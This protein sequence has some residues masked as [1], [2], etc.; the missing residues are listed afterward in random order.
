MKIRTSKV[1]ILLWSLAVQFMYAQQKTITGTVSDE[2]GPLP[3]VTVL[4]KNT[5]QG[6]ETDF[7][8]N[9]AIK[10]K[11]GDVLVFSYIGMKTTEK[12]VGGGIPSNII[13]VVMQS[14]NLLEEV[15]VTALG[16]KRDKKSL[17]YATQEVKGDAVSTVKTT[18]FI[19]SLSGQ[20]AGLSINSTGTLGG[21]ANVVIRGNSS[22]TG[23]NQA[24][25][26]VDG[27]PIGNITNTNPNDKRLEDQ[28]IGKGG[29]DYGNAASDINPDDIESI[30][31]LKGAAAT[32]LYG[33][34]GSN[35]VIMITTKKGKRTK[36]LGITISSSATMST[37]DRSTLPVY[38]N[39]YGAGYGQ[40]YDDPS[41]YFNY[42]DVDGDGSPDLTTP[43]SEDASFG[44]AFNPNTLVYQWNSIYPDLPTYQKATPWV[45]AKNT[46]NSIWEVGGTY[47]NSVSIDGGSDISTFR[48]GFTNLL[49]DGNLPNSNIKRNSINFSAS[50]DI[51]DKLTASVVLNYVK[52]NGRG[53]YGTGYNGNNLMQS[54]RQWWQVNVDIEQ[55]KQAY[56]A[57]RRNISWNPNSATN[58][59]PIFFDNP[60][61]VLYENFQT[62]V[63]NRYYGNTSLNWKVNNWLSILGRFAF[64]TYSELQEERI[65][66]GS[67]D[68]SRYR[69]YNNNVSE[70]NYDLIA[71]FNTDIS[72]KINFDG[73][74]G[75][76][77]RRNERNNITA[78]TNGGLAVAGLFSLSNSVNNPEAPIEYDEIQMVDGIYGRASFGFDDTYF[79]EGT[80]RTDRNSSLPIDKNRYQYWS[81]T[82]SVLLSKLIDVQ[83]L[84]FSKFRANYGTVGAGTIPY[85]IYN[86][87][88]F[89]TPF[90]NSSSATNPDVN[91]NP[92]LENEKQQN[93]EVGLEATLF[94]KRLGF[95]L[96][97]YQARN[98]NQI[99]PVPVSNS[100]G[101]EE[102]L[103]NA[104]TIENKGV[105]LSL[106]GTILKTEDFKW[107][108]NINWSRN[109]NKVVEL[110][111]VNNLQ[112][113][114]L[115]GGVSINATPGLPYGIIRGNDLVYH[116]NGQPIVTQ[117]G[118]SSDIGKYEITPT[119]NNIIG[120][121]NPDWI[122]GIRNAFSYKNFNFSFLIDVKKG[123]DLFSLDTWYGYGTGLYDFTAGDNDLGNP[124]RNTLDNGGGV[125]LPGVTPDGKPNTVRTRTDNL[126]NPWGWANAANSQ[127]VYDSGFVKLREANFTYSFGKELLGNTFKAASISLIGR[128]LWI[129]DKNVPYADPEA[130]L[131]L[132]NIQ[133]YQSGAYPAVKEFG[134]SV[135]LQF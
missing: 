107:D 44:G 111:K 57:T 50:H 22:L 85:R 10:A 123:G 59:N 55:Q 130:G 95:D 20:V 45:A 8:G 19:N 33:E 112:L 27:V 108:A 134:A 38:Q 72:E 52:V 114:S 26:V 92:D 56:F 100:T 87:F 81:V 16:I 41:G 46:P 73:N 93:W 105:E 84:N 36:G 15:V 113:A 40:F 25:F 48:L 69:R 47:V 68:V 60:Y 86:I 53:R 24:L 116:E 58:L 97:Y 28:E 42:T 96:S 91:N 67:Q 9:Y 133:G 65:N 121:I 99:I 61:W 90:G 64:D 126:E 39:R 120:D 76:N 6:T 34:R 78:S 83:W 122:G 18:N 131:S 115:Q 1:L 94:K 106:W 32:A 80:L 7:D 71:S 4:V 51:N 35:G 110:D 66:L 98:I 3:G 109:R 21:S 29:Y 104:G 88:E 13:N 129:I 125:V 118:S 119:S 23:N 31:V 54:F 2:S 82:G 101:Y 75:F 127:H 49:Q 70:F 74:L 37:V 128:N 77:L 12:T 14:D 63:R 103:L 30:N 11:T 117:T 62:D 102:I 132:G 5:S 17:G 43:F 79:V 89:N 135:K 124:V